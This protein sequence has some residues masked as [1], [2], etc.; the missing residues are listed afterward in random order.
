MKTTGGG[1]VGLNCLLPVLE[2]GRTG[3]AGGGLVGPAS[4]SSPCS[5]VRGDKGAPWGLSC[6]GTD[7]LHEDPTS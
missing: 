5:H 1:G 7:T 6:K 3:Y 4:S 2:V